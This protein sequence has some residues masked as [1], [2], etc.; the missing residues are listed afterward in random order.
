[1]NWMTIW[2]P[3]QLTRRMS[4]PQTLP[5]YAPFPR[6]L[7]PQLKKAIRMLILFAFLIGLALGTCS[8]FL[9]MYFMF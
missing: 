6:G 5:S 4:L 3:C 2:M 8:M 7:N 1:M 9:L